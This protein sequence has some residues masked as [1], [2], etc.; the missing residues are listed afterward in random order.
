MLVYGQ[1]QNSKAKHSI[2]TLDNTAMY[3]IIVCGIIPVVSVSPSPV[4]IACCSLVC[5]VYS[6]QESE[7][8]VLALLTAK[9]LVS[10]QYC[11]LEASLG[12][13]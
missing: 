3:L 7:K 4:S 13:R 10:S 6:I 2:I 5:I 8:N 1:L 12:A 9:L 11:W